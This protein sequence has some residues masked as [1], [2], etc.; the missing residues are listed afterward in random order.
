MSSTSARVGGIAAPM[1]ALMSSIFEEL[2]MLNFGIVAFLAGNLILTL[3][4]TL[5]KTPP[6]TIADCEGTTEEG[7]SVEMN[8]I[9]SKKKTS[10]V[11]S[12]VEQP[13][14]DQGV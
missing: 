6:E 12:L 7:E 4:E 3:P 10:E 13:A 11:T 14:G 1:V 2:P 8:T 9:S 5:G